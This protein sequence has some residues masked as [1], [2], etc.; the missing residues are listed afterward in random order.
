VTETPPTPPTPKGTGPM[1]TTCN[2]QTAKGLTGLCESCRADHDADPTAWEEFGRHSAGERN[3]ADLQAEMDTER[4]RV[5]AA[6]DYE[7][8]PDMPL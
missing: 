4:E 3:W 1:P 6:G 7:P 8:D 5:A 2:H